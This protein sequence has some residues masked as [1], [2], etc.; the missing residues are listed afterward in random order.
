LNFGLL[1]LGWRI[2]LSIAD[3]RTE[4]LK[5]QAE[6]VRDYHGQREARATR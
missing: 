4:F 5:L 1:A 2:A 3:L 6:H